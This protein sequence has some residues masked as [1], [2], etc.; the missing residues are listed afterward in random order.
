MVDDITRAPTP[1]AFEGFACRASAMM[2]L[3]NALDVAIEHVDD[4]LEAG[5]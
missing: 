4:V 1:T 2:W 3:V 5:R